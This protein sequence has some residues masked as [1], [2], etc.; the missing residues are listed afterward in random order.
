MSQLLE[1]TYRHLGYLQLLCGLFGGEHLYERRLGQGDITSYALDVETYESR[2]VIFVEQSPALKNFRDRYNLNN[3]LR[4]IFKSKDDPANVHD[5]AA[6]WD[7][8]P[9]KIE[10]NEVLS[11]DVVPQNAKE[12]GEGD[13]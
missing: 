2:L 13:E 4:K 1:R 7:V 11:V 3:L 12:G 5:D 6:K 10:M 8:V 9:T